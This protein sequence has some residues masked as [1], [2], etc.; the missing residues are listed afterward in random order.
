M[1]VIIDLIEDI[2]ESIANDKSF[3][4]GAMGLSENENGEFMPLWQS[5][6]CSYRLDEDAKKMFLFLGKEKALE[7]GSLLEILNALS[8][9]SMM[10]ELYVSYT[11]E[12][13]RVDTPL[14]GFGESVS[15]KRYHLFISE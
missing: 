12:N 1:K 4:L 2:R 13:Q 14:M 15:D 7:V 11:K 9:E 3:S 8:N 5:S 6:I 10:Y